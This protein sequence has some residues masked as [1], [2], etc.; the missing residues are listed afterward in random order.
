MKVLFVCT[1]LAFCITIVTMKDMIVSKA[2]V[3]STGYIK[4][5]TSKMNEELARGGSL[6]NLYYGQLH[7]HSSFSDGEGTCEEAFKYASTVPKNMDYFAVT[8]HSQ[9]FD[10]YKKATITDGSASSEWVQG[11]KLAKKYTT[12]KFVGLYAYEMTWNATLGIGH[13]NTFNTTGF[14]S[15]SL[16]K[17]YNSATGLQEYYKTL[18]QA[19]NSLSQFNHPGVK[20]GHF[21]DFEYVSPEV[22]KLIQL[23]EMP[24]YR[25]TDDIVTYCKYYQRAL[26]KGWHVSP[27]NNQDNHGKDWGT[28][29]D[30]RSVIWSK[31]LSETAIYDAIRRNR[32]YST[33]DRD[34]YLKY[35]FDGYLMGSKVNI[36]R[37]NE[38]ATVKLSLYDPTDKAIG[39]LEIV[40]NNGDV[41]VRKNITT[42][43]II[44]TY[45]V[46]TEYSYYYIRIQ[47]ADGDKIVS[48][49]VWIGYYAT[50]TEVKKVSA[51]EDNSI[52][53]TTEYINKTEATMNKGDANKQLKV[54]STVEDDISGDEGSGSEDAVGDDSNLREEPLDDIGNDAIGKAPVK[55]E[56]KFSM[57][58]IIIVAIG[59]FIAMIVEAIIIVRLKKK[60]RN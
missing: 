10:N 50:K 24:G 42:K 32:T 23:I 35:T 38:V 48:A 59:L 26:D 9:R 56:T 37:L 49:P 41:I 17:Y 60:L 6:Y 57:T 34:F 43:K 27:T 11:H 22:D 47:Q 52:L 53:K 3:Y 30:K 55:T 36:G 12:E 25:T 33:E 21:K 44:A 58:I 40:G 20:W 2:S 45:D 14:V 4:T 29:N 7:S 15:A 51:K 28:L 54:S 31:T 13:M 16:S 8:D 5:I 46:P 1:M 39:Q 18:Q 19:P